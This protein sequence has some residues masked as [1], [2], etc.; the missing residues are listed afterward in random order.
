MV[1]AG[2]FLAPLRTGL[3]GGD[4]PFAPA[5]ARRESRHMTECSGAD[6]VR[7]ALLGGRTRRRGGLTV[8]R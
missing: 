2:Q 8:A 6:S 7:R 3:L 4:L 1:G 5:L